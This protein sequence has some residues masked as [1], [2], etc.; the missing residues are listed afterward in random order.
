MY[1]CVLTNKNEEENNKKRIHKQS[2]KKKK[3]NYY[4]LKSNTFYVSI[5]YPLPCGIG[6]LKK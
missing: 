5:Q 1:V 3:E 4:I 2:K 6:F